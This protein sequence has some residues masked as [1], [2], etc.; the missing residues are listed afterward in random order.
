M[1]KTIPFVQKNIFSKEENENNFPLKLHYSRKF[2]LFYCNMGLWCSGITC[3]S[4][5]QG[6]EF[7]PRQVHFL[8]YKIIK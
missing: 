3:A 1:K 2:T 5:A 7:N 4:Q 6:P 8:L